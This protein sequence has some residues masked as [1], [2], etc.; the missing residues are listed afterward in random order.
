MNA[1]TIEQ[2]QSQQQSM[3]YQ[4]KRLE[5]NMIAIFEKYT[6]EALKRAKP[7]LKKIKDEKKHN[8]EQSK[9]VWDAGVAVEVEL[10]EELEDEAAAERLAVYEQAGKLKFTE[11]EG[12]KRYNRNNNISG[13]DRRNSNRT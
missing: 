5:E 6:D 4:M 7:E 2:I 11:E 13:P 1:P 9:L 3:Q 8:T 10:E 12:G